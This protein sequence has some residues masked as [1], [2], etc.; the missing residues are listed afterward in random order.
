MSQKCVIT[1]WNLHG[2]HT[3]KP[4]LHE[5]LNKTDIMLISEHW[6]GQN[7]LF[8][9]NEVHCDYQG[10]FKSGN[11]NIADTHAWGGVGVLW[12][13]AIDVFVE[14]VHIDSYRLCAIKINQGVGLRPLF[15]IS[16]Y[17]PQSG[18]GAEDYKDELLILEECIQT[19]LEQGDTLVMGDLNCHFGPEINVRGW[20]KT[21]KN[22]KFLLQVLQR[23]SMFV[24]DLGATC[25]G[26][27]YTYNN[28]VNESY[29]DHCIINTGMSSNVIDCYV[30][31]DLPINMSDHLPMS[32]ILD[33][34]CTPIHVSNPRVSVAWH[35]M[36][37]EQTQMLYTERLDV[38]LNETLNQSGV[39]INSL[40]A[41]NKFTGLNPQVWY[42]M[43]VNSIAKVSAG[44]PSTQFNQKLKPYWSKSLKDLGKGKKDAFKAWVLGG[45]PRFAGNLLWENYK[46]AKRQFRKEQRRKQIEYETKQMQELENLEEIDSRFYWHLVN[47][48]RKVYHR[49]ITPLNIDGNMVTE[50]KLIVNCWKDYFQKLFTPTENNGYDANFKLYVENELQNIEVVNHSTSLLSTGFTESDFMES[51][52]HMRLRKAPGY[53]LVSAE[54]VKHAGPLCRQCL[55][56]LYNSIVSHESM[57][58]GMK[59]GLL[60]PIPKGSSDTSIRENNRGISL[61]TVFYKQFQNLLIGRFGPS[62]ENCIDVVQG[63]GKKKISCAHTSMLLRETIAYN[64]ENKKRVFVAFLDVKKAYDTVWPEGLKLKLYKTGIDNKLYKV[65]INMLSD[66][67]CA[68]FV[69]NEK[70][71]WFT[72]KQGIPQGAPLSLWS[73]QVFMDDLIRE[74]KSSGLGANIGEIQIACPAYADDLAIVTTQHTC[75][76]SLLAKAHAHSL[77]WRYSFSAKKSE[78]LVFESEKKSYKFW[79]GSEEIPIV[80]CAKHLGSLLYKSNKHVMEY[81]E[82]RVYKGKQAIMSVQGLGST[83]VPTSVKLRSKVYWTVSVPMITFGHE[84]MEV[85]QSCLNYLEDNHWKIAKRIQGLSDQA[86]DPAVLPLLGWMTLTGYINFL[87]LTFL[88]RVLLL[89]VRNIYRKVVI[90]R[91]IDYCNNSTNSQVGPVAN[92]LNVAKS[93]D[94]LESILSSLFNGFTVTNSQWK[95]RVKVVIRENEWERHKATFNLYKSLRLFTYTFNTLGFWPWW[96]YASRNPIA[97]RKTKLLAQLLTGETKF[98]CYINGD[99]FCTLCL[100]PVLSALAHILF[101]CTELTLLRSNLWITV[102]NVAPTSFIFC[103]NTMSALEKTSFIMNGMNSKYIQEFHLLYDTLLFFVTSMFEELEKQCTLNN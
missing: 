103:M 27:K 72:V 65:L 3:A 19:C 71:D 48:S 83:H 26:P 11:N 96:E 20:G 70:S 100:S 15:I 37:A 21:S 41:N 29:I 10:F 43:I 49:K 66:F 80:E 73:Y 61:L 14:P 47:K 24:F 89:P 55:L 7:E 16:V 58:V 28:G 85:S 67:Q 40:L 63:A 46:S 34:Q 97:A 82:G 44:L 38:L 17:M 32:V 81:V 30:H 13:K 2:F 9:I 84:V 64:L 31:D 52:K 101:E 87:K 62:M 54:H 22:A 79:L 68:A 88:W 36:S 102:E 6:L 60:V 18:C 95:K 39:N 86:P 4:Y 94:V 59:R 77:K 69:A 5:L 99:K 50:P 91:I 1:A 56:V 33:M 93:Y 78:I 53:D 98:R 90:Q 8:K 75:M 74:I 23:N 12:H 45:R 51:I 92:A 76:Q 35:K 57:P 25:H 42:E